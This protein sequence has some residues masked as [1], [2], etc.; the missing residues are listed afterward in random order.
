MRM[1]S[2]TTWC[3]ISESSHLLFSHVAQSTLDLVSRL[4]SN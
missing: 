4:F 1:L 3:E 2:R